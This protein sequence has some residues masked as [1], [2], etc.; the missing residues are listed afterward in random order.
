MVAER[1]VTY[2]SS[3]TVELYWLRTMASQV[4]ELDGVAE[5]DSYIRGYH[6]HR[7]I[8]SLVVGEILLFKREPENLVDTSAVAVWKESIR[9][10]Q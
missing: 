9:R 7:D 4:V 10:H 3:G 8:W 6:A 1:G 5:F 2:R